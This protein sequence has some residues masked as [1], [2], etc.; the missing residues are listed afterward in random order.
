MLLSTAGCL[1][2]EKE[3]TVVTHMG[4]C[5]TPDPTVGALNLKK[6]NALLILF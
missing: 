3:G 2:E 6:E 5:S 1:Y 4:L